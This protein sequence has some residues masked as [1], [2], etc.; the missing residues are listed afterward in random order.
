MQQRIA[1]LVQSKPGGANCCL[2]GI[3]N[4]SL[5]NLKQNPKQIKGKR[6]YMTVM[7]KI[8]PFKLVF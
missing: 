3:V 7:P 2:P 4:F 1:F 6:K 8:L 5:L